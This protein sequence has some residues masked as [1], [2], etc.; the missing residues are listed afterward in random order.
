MHPERAV[1]IMEGND[2]MRTYKKIMDGV[3]SVEKFVLIVVMVVVTV[4]TFVN[5]VV[6][7]LTPFSFAWSEELVVNLFVLMTMLGCALCAR[8]GSLISLT[9][10][11]DRLNI[12]ARKVFEVIIAVA[13][14]AFWAILLYTGVDKVLSQ[15]ASGKQTF[16]LRWPEWVFTIFLPIGA[17]FLLL[18]SIEFLIDVFRGEVDCVKEVEE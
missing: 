1:I 3:A 14:C 9:L 4:I 8:E 12:K 10:I 6:R 15:M 17:V 16:S 7:Y 13:N 2:R 18:H 11:F 5:V